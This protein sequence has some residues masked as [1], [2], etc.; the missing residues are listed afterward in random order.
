MLSVGFAVHAQDAGFDVVDA[1]APVVD[2]G[3]SSLPQRPPPPPPPSFVEENF[4]GTGVL[5]GTSHYEVAFMLGQG[6]LLFAD[7]VAPIP[8]NGVVLRERNG[9]LSYLLTVLAGQA[10]S[11]WA[12]AASAVQ[13][14]NVQSSSS[15]NIR[16]NADGTRD[17]ITTT[18]TTADVKVLKSQEQVDRETEASN[19]SISG[20]FVGHTFGELA[21]Y[22][23]IPALS[24]GR[25][26]G[27]GYEFTFGGHGELFQLMKLPV[28]LDVGVHLANVRVKTPV[29]PGLGGPFLYHSAGGILSRL[30]VPLTRFAAISVEWVLNF[31]SIGYLIDPEDTLA[32][33]SRPLS[34]LRF[35][36][37][38][39]ATDHVFLRG[40]A[41]FGALG[42]SDGRL[43]LSVTAG[44]RL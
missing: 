19:K 9:I 28:V 30:H 18:T 12:I 15:T 26:A 7:G 32:T 2:A 24:G 21:I 23:D 33:G 39:F 25:P 29:S 10:L 36:L 40:E 42:V 8:L 43:G 22:A 17:A 1:G 6:G 34:P 3:V 20:G 27:A 5:V 35:T 44:V 31:I 38:V 11:S 4:H 41:T 37:D 16:Y 14:S 13:V